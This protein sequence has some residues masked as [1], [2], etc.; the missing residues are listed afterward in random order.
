MPNFPYNTTFDPGII[1]AILCF[2]HPYGT[3]YSIHFAAEKNISK[4]V[5]LAGFA[6]GFEIIKNEVKRGGG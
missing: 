5:N 6:T 2:L 4:T 3:I 1:Y